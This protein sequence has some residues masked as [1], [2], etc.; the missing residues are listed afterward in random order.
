[1]PFKAFSRSVEMAAAMSV[2]V[3]GAVV[4]PPALPLA[5]SELCTPALPLADSVAGDSLASTTR[6]TRLSE[7]KSVGG[8]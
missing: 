6:L 8:S 4:E 3:S 7:R 1:M 5:K 2:A